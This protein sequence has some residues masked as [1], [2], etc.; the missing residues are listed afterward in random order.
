[1]SEIT[2]IEAG[3]KAGETRA[4][5]FVSAEE[6]RIRQAEATSKAEALKLGGDIASFAKRW[7]IVAAAVL[8]IVAV[9]V[10]LFR[11]AA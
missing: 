1:M 5:G 6:A 10:L 7:W 8:T 9:A 3:A 2:K 4:A 11:H